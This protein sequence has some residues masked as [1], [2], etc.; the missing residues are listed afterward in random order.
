MFQ[1]SSLALTYWGSLRDIP[2]TTSESSLVQCSPLF[3]VTLIQFFKL[4]GACYLVLLQPRSL[5][6]SSTPLLL[7]RH[8]WE[9]S[10]ET[11]LVLLLKLLW[12][13]N[14]VVVLVL[15]LPD[16]PQPGT[17]MSSSFFR[18]LLKTMRWVKWYALSSYSILIC[19]L[20]VS[21]FNVIRLWHNSCNTSN[22]FCL[23]YCSHSLSFHKEDTTLVAANRTLF[24]SG[25]VF[26]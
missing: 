12:C 24:P 20:F 10:L 1:A 11:R 8:G 25:A 23:K 4:C 6:L 13:N 18:V 5:V 16:S 14:V 15:S 9:R 17:D 7:R 2:C 19:R 21:N 3:N 26:F 22:N